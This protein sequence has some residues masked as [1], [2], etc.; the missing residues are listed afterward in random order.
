MEQECAKCKDERSG[1]C[2]VA[3]ELAVFAEMKF[4]TAPA[5]FANS[6][7]KYDANKTRAQSYANAHNKA[8]TYSQAKDTVSIDALRE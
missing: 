3:Q 4:A 2:R 6:D 7:I 8:V 1:R 5:I